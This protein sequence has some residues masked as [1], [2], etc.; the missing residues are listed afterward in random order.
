MPTATEILPETE[1]TGITA[2]MDVA[3]AAV[4]VAVVPFNFTTLFNI[5]VLNPVPLIMTVDPIAPIAGEKLMIF[6]RMTKSADEVAVLPL[7]V[8]VIL[9]V[10]ASAGT[11]TVIEVEVTTV[12]V[13]ALVLNFTMLFAVVVLNPVPVIVTLEPMSPLVG[14]KLV[15]VGGTIKSAA[16]VVVKS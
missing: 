1:P 12:T 14:E 5:V 10:K 8:T 3:V 4:T 7:T 9:S 13:A 16:E 2:V 11:V 15:M 6:G